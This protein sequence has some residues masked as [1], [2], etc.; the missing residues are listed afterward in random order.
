MEGTSQQNPQEPMII[1]NPLEALDQ[2]KEEPKK[3]KEEIRSD[4]YTYC[5]YCG[6]VVE[7]T[8]EICPNCHRKLG[9]E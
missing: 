2:T 1:V 9:E 5:P 8:A 4:L 7:K 6:E 3:E